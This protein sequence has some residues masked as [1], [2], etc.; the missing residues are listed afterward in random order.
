M[1]II[2][3]VCLVFRNYALWRKIAQN[4]LFILGPTNTGKTGLAGFLASQFNFTI[5]N[6][7]VVQTYEGLNFLANK[8]G[9]CRKEISNDFKINYTN[10]VDKSLFLPDALQKYSN[11]EFILVSKHKDEV[12]IDKISNFDEFYYKLLAQDFPSLP[13]S[14]NEIPNYFFDINQIGENFSVS[15]YINNFRKL[16]KYSS[17]PKIITGGTIYYA[18]HLIKGTQFDFIPEPKVRHVI[19]PDELEQIKL[20]LKNTDKESFALYANN[21]S[22]MIKAYE[23]NKSTGEKFS[24][25]YFK[26]QEFIEDF[27]LIILMPRDRQ[28]Y[29]SK[30]EEAV[31]ARIN[32]PLCKEEIDYL[33]KSLLPEQI[34]W[35][36]SYSYEYKYAFEYFDSKNQD[37][38]ILK[39]L[40]IK[41]RQYAKR[42]VTFLNK[43]WRDL[44][45]L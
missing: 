5:V 9:F 45:L 20:E 21:P 29:V 8:P 36:K 23:F 32:S 37:E 34:D 19:R 31:R 13:K 27:T 4:M 17:E 14:R 6:C 18:Y 1:V 3:N 11:L 43:L 35:L 40:F 44:S 25:K 12:T 15:D 24:S 42:Q 33:K 22:R 16:C 7:D 41:E 26:S 30:L 28:V 38:E 2:A 10:T 39:T